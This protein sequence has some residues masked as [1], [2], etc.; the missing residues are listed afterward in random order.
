MAG[1]DYSVNIKQFL[2][3]DKSVIEVATAVTQELK[4]LPPGLV[5]SIEFMEIMDVFEEAVELNDVE[6][7]DAGLSDLYDWAD[8]KRVWLGLK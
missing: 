4:R 6:V 5:N 2:N 1:W 3:P 8:E 7:F